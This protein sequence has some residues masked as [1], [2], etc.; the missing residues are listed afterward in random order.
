[1]EKVMEFGTRYKTIEEIVSILEKNLG[2]AFVRREDG[3]TGVS[4]DWAADLD[5]MGFSYFGIDVEPTRIWDLE[6][7]EI[8]LQ[9]KNW[10]RYTFVV[11][12]S[13]EL[14]ECISRIRDLIRQG[15]LK[16]EELPPLRV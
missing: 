2:I 3:E 5:E 4:Y 16:A 10:A 9:N 8:V 7:R 12:I 11:G 6:E 14:S 13:S 15:E 1:M